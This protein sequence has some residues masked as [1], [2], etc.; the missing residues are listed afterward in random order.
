MQQPQFSK[1]ERNFISFEYHKRKGH[2]DFLPGL[3]ADFRIKFPNTRQPSSRPVRRIY[4]KQMKLGTVLNVNSSTSPGASHSGRPKSVR[5]PRNVVRVKRTM[6]RDARKK[7][8]DGDQSPVNSARR[9]RI[10]MDKS[11]WSRIGREIK[12]HPYRPVRR[13]ELK[14]EDLPRRSRF[15]NWIRTL[16]DQDLGKFLFSDEANFQLN[17][18]VNSQNVRRYAPL[19]ADDPVL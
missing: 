15:C 18:N 12:Y 10:G 19:K 16:S 2:R 11:S 8:G 14:P 6:D 13:Q 1:D 7:I 5:T 3:V 9:N 17:G 4:S